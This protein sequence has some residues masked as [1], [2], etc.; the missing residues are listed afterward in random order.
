MNSIVSHLLA[1]VVGT[2]FGPRLVEIARNL[3]NAVLDALKE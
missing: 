1:V 2:V 3:L